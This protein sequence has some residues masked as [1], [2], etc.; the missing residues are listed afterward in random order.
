MPSRILL[1]V[2][3]C[4]LIISPASSR[5]QQAPRVTAELS[6]E[7]TIVGQ[8]L[9][10]RVK[11]L[12]PS[13]MP[14]PP[15]F[16]D[17][18]VPG[19]LIR[20]P[21]RASSPTSETI[22]GE[23]WSGV[24]RSYRLYP[25]VPGPVTLP[26][27]DLQ[28]TYSTG[29]ASDAETT[30]VPL[31][32]ITFTATLPDGARDLSP[33]ILASGFTLEETVE[34]PEDLAVGGAV[35]RVVTASIAGTTPI[36]IPPLT[37]AETPPG[38]RAYPDEPRVSDREER[39]VLSGERVER[40]VFLPELAGSASLP[41]IAF[42]WYNI[43]T[44]KIER[45]ELPEHAFDVAP[46][47][48]P[49][50]LPPDPRQLALIV[51]LVTAALALLEAVRRFGLPLARRWLATQVARWRASE[52]HAHHQVTRALARR[53]LTALNRALAVWQP[54]L[55]A[56]ADPALLAPGR[57]RLDAALARIGAA[58]YGPNRGTG[59]D[60]GWTAARQAC[61]ALRRVARSGRAGVAAL[62]ALNP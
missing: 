7:E 8:P 12:V 32:P 50:R 44:G 1:A 40:V 51:A 25:L 11:V 24:Q 53:D 22:G 15:V 49:A 3:A 2:L 60:A 43:E 56:M 42:D 6:A 57:A 54:Q 48:E 29:G 23:S 39:G 30:A 13:F 33:L 38:L 62:P 27:G 26:G 45:A 10:L 5:A 28:V 55:E 21:E 9:M 18:E 31:P 37:G 19:L 46:G 61:A 34:I 35:T 17:F 20:L 41:A 52:H 59:E 4:A 58:R 47:P 36:L 16:P 14:S